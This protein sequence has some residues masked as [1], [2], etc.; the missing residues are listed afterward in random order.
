MQALFYTLEPPLN[1]QNDRVYASV[2][3]KK[4]FISPRRLL[5]MRSTF[6]KSIMVSI[7]VSK[8]VMTK[9]IFVNPGMKSNGQYN[10]NA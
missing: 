10:H 5:R 1:L 8:M 2:G 7:A 6:T 4:R 9:L 3:M